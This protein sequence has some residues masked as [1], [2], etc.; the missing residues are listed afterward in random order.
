MANLNRNDYEVRYQMFDHFALE[1]QRA[2]YAT[3][4]KKYRDSARQVNRWRAAAA[5]MTGLAAA[6][7]GFFVQTAFITGGRCSSDLASVPGDCSTLQFIVGVFIILSVAMPALGGFFSSL[8][9]LYQWDRLITIYDSALENIEVADAQSPLP[10]MNDLEFRASVAAYI[11]GTLL[12]MSD[13]TAQWGQSI[14]TPPQTTSFIEK[15][16]EKADK[17]GGD[18]EVSYPKQ[19]TPTGSPAKPIEIPM[20]KLPESQPQTPPPTTTPPET[21]PTTPPTDEGGVG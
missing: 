3:V 9:D 4:L 5:F 7:A 10:D 6:L 18:A 11:E 20:A 15:M 8:A 14:R 21:P 17:L 19:D 16:R 13:E 2:Y 12:V 1:D